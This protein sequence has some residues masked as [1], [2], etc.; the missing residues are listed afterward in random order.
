MARKRDDQLLGALRAQ[1]VRRSLA[2]TISELDP[3]GRKTSRAEK[4]ARDTVRN[5]RGAADQIQ[6]RVL[7]TSN[8]SEAAKKAAATRKRKSAQR[9]AAA[10]KGAR[11]RA[12]SRS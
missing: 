10:K 11:T 8:R 12:K 5:L 2:R 6:D 7:G 1:G 3:R 9:S 4:I